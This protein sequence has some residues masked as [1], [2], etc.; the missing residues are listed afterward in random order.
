MQHGSLR[1]SEL[2]GRTS[3]LPSL[4]KFTLNCLL[5][6]EGSQNAPTNFGSK[7][8]SNNGWDPFLEDPALWLLHWN[9]LSPCYATAWDFTFTTFVQLNSQ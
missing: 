9:L 5:Q 4:N 7:L 8:L 2:E 6:S 3:S 1:K